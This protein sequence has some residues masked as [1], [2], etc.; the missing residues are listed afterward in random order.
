M[1]P[2][3]PGR[4]RTVALVGGILAIV[5]VGAGGAF[6]FQQ[7]SGGG[8]QPESV[9]PANTLAFAKVDLDPSAG[10]KLDAIRFIRKFPDAKG[11][12]KEDS[13]LREVVFKSLQDDGQLKGVD[14]AKDIEPWLG[15]RIG[16][17]RRSP[18]PPPTPSRSWSS[19][20]R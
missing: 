17:G 10:Q 8:A 15:Q 5:A 18:G 12:V 2:P 3:R 16:F 1:Q 9:L 13:D 4:G 19:R 20:S 11:E 14:Y 6:A 7:V